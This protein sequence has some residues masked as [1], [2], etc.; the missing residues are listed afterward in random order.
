MKLTKS[1]STK[2]SQWVDIQ[3]IIVDTPLN[4]KTITV[5]GIKL[6]VELDAKIY[7]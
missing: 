1:S 3:P 6:T 4:D 2:L 7:I 5:A